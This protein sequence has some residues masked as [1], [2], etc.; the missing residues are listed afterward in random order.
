MRT[1]STGV[2][3]TALVRKATGNHLMNTTSLGKTQSLV[4]GFC[5]ARNRACNAV[6][7]ID[8]DS[9]FVGGPLEKQLMLKGRPSLIKESKYEIHIN[10]LGPLVVFS[11]AQANLFSLELKRTFFSSISFDVLAS[12]C[13]S[14]SMLLLS[15]STSLISFFLFSNSNLSFFLLVFDDSLLLTG[16]ASYWDTKYRW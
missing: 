1:H 11:S 16:T 4:S 15:A 7:I 13:S 3:K 9:C 5:Y 8:N 6:I 12:S 2:V 14:A 10:E